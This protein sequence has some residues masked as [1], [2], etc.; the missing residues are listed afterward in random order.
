MSK[1]GLHKASSAVHLP[2][3]GVQQ[4][5][6]R[7]HLGFDAS[8]KPGFRSPGVPTLKTQANRLRTIHRFASAN[9]VCSCAVF[10]AKP[11]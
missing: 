9:N 2:E 4:P 10:L 7:S 1:E 6:N 8:P 3:Y 5:L 11:R